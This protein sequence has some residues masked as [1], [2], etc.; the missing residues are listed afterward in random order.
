MFFALTDVT[1]LWYR[2]ASVGNVTKWSKTGASSL[3]QYWNISQQKYN[4]DKRKEKYK[5]GHSWIIV[6]SGKVYYMTSKNKQC[7]DW[8]I[9]SFSIHF[10]NRCKWLLSASKQRSKV[11]RNKPVWVFFPWFHQTSWG[12]S[13][14]KFCPW[15]SCSFHVSIAIQPSAHLPWIHQE[16]VLGTVKRQSGLLQFFKRKVSYNM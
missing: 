10:S 15:W 12:Q 6:T 2:R 7:N 4:K 1:G 5:Q 13:C 3:G 16:V 11:S 14:G 9:L 8:S